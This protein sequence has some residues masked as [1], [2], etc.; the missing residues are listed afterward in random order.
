M[1]FFLKSQ[2]FIIFFFFEVRIEIYTVDDDDVDKSVAG[3]IGVMCGSAMV[4]GIHHIVCSQ[5]N[6]WNTPDELVYEQDEP[7]IVKKL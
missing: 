5:D 2:I 3:L 4:C 6:D 7:E 1:I